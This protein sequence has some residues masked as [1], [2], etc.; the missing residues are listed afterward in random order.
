M[1]ASPIQTPHPTRRSDAQIVHDLLRLQK[2]TQKISSTLDIDL[3]MDK[4]VHEVAESFGC[5][6]T[7]VWLADHRRGDMVLAG[8]QGCTVH[9]K[10]HRFKIG[11]EGMVGWVAANGRTRYAPD[12]TLD[13]FY[14]RCEPETKSE[15]V[16]PLRAP[17]VHGDRDHGRGEIIGAFVAGHPELDGFTGWQRQLL[18]GLAEHIAIAVHNARRFRREQKVNEAGAREAAEARIVQEALLPK[19][20]PFAPGFS[21]QGRSLPAG[22]VGGDWYDFI[23][24]SDGKWGIVLADVSGKGMA[25]ALL[26]SATRAALRSMADTCFGPGG[27]LQKL[28]RQLMT[29]M[30]A[31]RFVTMIFGIFDP[32]ARKLTF[33]NAGHPWPIHANGAEAHALATERGL[34][35]GISESFYSEVDVELTPGSRLLFYSDGISEAENHAAEEY[36]QE[37]IFAQLNNEDICA[38]TLLEDI[39]RF[40]GGRAQHDDATVILIRAE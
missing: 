10:G 32:A 3:L 5:L 27:V 38:D 36:G 24:L 12:V 34:P 26:M 20:S 7:S 18:E 25:A 19:A 40:A 1:A 9:Q 15:I 22:A 31:G 23:P 14:I 16:V 30:P 29:D 37:R 17:A 11:E 2:A 28:N 13:E 4:I 39:K 21:V 6:E 8:V 35:L 33:A